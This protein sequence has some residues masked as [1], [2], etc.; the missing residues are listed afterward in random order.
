MV[1]KLLSK[2]SPAKGLQYKASGIKV[3]SLT[4]YSYQTGG[5]FMAYT[6]EQFSAACNSALKA[7]PGP[8]G[9]QKVRALL[10]DVLKDK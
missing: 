6:L 5:V 2:R 7:E 4:P 3:S 9:R 1:P 8:E 10:Q